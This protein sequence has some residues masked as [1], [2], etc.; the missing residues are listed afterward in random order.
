LLS[1][2]LLLLLLD[3][4]AAHCCTQSCG[5]HVAV[6]LPAAGA[7]AASAG[8]GR[9]QGPVSNPAAGTSAVNCSTGGSS[10]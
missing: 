3:S 5:W 1:L 2:G 4:G 7:G 9:C 6:P 10:R 8:G